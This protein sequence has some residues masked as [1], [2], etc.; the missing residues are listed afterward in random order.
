MRAILQFELPDEEYQFMCAEQGARATLVL[1]RIDQE[2]RNRIKHGDD[3]GPVKAALQ[4]IRDMLRQECT[5]E[6]IEIDQ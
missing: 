3:S 6:R 4:E 5:E 2:L 1:S